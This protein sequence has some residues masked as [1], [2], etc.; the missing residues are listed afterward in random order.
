MGLDYSILTYIKKEK[1]KDSYNWLL[2][3]TDDEERE[4][5]INQNSV[6]IKGH[7]FS[8][9]TENNE[10]KYSTSIIFDID[11]PIIETLYDEYSTHKVEIFKEDFVSAYLGNGKIRIGN[12]DVSIN[13]LTEKEIYKIEFTAVTSAMSCMLDE[14][15]SAKNWII[16]FSQ[17]SES[18][19]SCINQEYYSYIILFEDGNK[20]YKKLTDDIYIDDIVF[21]IID[22]KNY[23]Q[24]RTV[25]KNK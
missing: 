1:L 16:E 13:Y 5:F 21:K 12:F 20:T 3:N 8:N 7:N 9:S 17:I 24:Q 4:I 19:L 23:C 14:S 18:I 11:L 22:N 25:L 15:E 10:I 2:N 6:L